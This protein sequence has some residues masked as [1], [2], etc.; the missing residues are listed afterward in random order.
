M[1]LPDGGPDVGLRLRHGRELI[2]RLEEQLGNQPPLVTRILAARRRPFPQL[3]DVAP[4]DCP[5]L[6]DALDAPP[7]VE[8][9][10]LADLREALRAATA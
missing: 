2:R 3:Y 9:G 1:R 8:T 6:L 10:K 7:T 5:V 4:E